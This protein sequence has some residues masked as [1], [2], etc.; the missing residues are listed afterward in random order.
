M[1]IRKI[2]SSVVPL[3]SVTKSLQEKQFTNIVKNMFF[4]DSVHFIALFNYVKFIS[5]RL[6]H[7][8]SRTYSY[9]LPTMQD[10]TTA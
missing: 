1:K 5:V 2:I 4:N 7:F 9:L 10:V 6:G 3:K 8:T